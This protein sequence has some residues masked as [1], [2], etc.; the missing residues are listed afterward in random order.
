MRS[1]VLHCKL[2]VHPVWQKDYEAFMHTVRF[3]TKLCNPGHPLTK[4]AAERLDRFVKENYLL[5][6]HF[7]MQDPVFCGNDILPIFKTA[8]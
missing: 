7:T 6:G 5:T 4:G 2:N 3:D 1:V 8:K